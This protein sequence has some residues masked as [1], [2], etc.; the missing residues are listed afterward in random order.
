MRQK[1]TTVLKILNENLM[2]KTAKPEGKG[3]SQQESIQ[4]KRQH[5]FLLQFMLLARA[6]CIAGK[7]GTNENMLSR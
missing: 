7:I 1:K 6:A 2:K 4:I 5:E 3:T